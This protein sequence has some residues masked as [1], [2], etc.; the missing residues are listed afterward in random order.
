MDKLSNEK[1]ID[2]ITK[3][4]RKSDI[5]TF[6]SINRKAK[7]FAENFNVADKAE[8]MAPSNAFITL[9]EHEANF[10]NNPK[11]RL[12]NPA[13]L[14]I[15]RI[16]KIFIESANSKICNKSKLLQWRISSSVIN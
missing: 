4:Y 16:S 13:K 9:K 3:M 11:C 15:G 14:E 6:N 5:D 12:I 10:E 1:L 7:K 2:N 8:C